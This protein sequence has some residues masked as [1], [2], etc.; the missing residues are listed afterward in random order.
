VECDGHRRAAGARAGAERAKAELEHAA[1]PGDRAARALGGHGRDNRAP[2]AAPA[3]T[4]DIIV[5]AEGGEKREED[6]YGEERAGGS[7]SSGHGRGG[8]AWR[9]R[10]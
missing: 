5:R 2:P 4:A 7:G 9:V 6:E 8:Q 3:A 10:N 1:R